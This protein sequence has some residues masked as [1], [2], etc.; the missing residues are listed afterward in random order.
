MNRVSQ[1]I[2][3]LAV[4]ALTISAGAAMRTHDEALIVPAGT[5]VVLAFDQALSS[6][7]ATVGQNVALHVK[8]NVMVGDKTII[9]AGTKAT[10]VISS[11]EGRKRYGINARL[12]IAL[13]PIESAYGKSIPI[14]PRTKGEAVSGEK[15]AQAG[16]ATAGGAILLGP[17]GLV[18]GL[19]IHG[20]E[21][22]INPGDVLVS[23]V[24]KDIVLMIRSHPGR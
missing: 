20:K 15:S 11:V 2:A 23:E 10:G 19:F 7:T 21:V 24:A 3:I 1:T 5:A 22:N 16:A 6:K 13:N 12:R 14:Q 4:L 9:K 8:D 18:G 17:V